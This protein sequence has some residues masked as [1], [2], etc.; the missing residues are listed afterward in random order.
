VT[1]RADE[2][3]HCRDTAGT[4][5]AEGEQDAENPANKYPPQTED[6]NDS[7]NAEKAGFDVHG[8]GQRPR[9]AKRP[10]AIATMKLPPTATT[11]ARPHETGFLRAAF[12][13]FCPIVNTTAHRNPYTSPRLLLRAD[14]VVQ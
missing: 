4:F 2:K 7:G 14:E 9:Y 10:V 6:E 5:V 8:S 11:I 1:D 3:G 13:T 12:S